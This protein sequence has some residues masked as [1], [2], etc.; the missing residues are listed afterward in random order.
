LSLSPKKLTREG[1]VPFS[2]EEKKKTKEIYD[3]MSSQALRVLAFA[4]CPLENY[5]KNDCKKESEK[6]LIWVGMM[7]MIDPP[8]ADVAKAIEECQQLGIKVIMITGD[9]E[10]TARAIA[11]KVN[12]LRSNSKFAIDNSDNFVI[13]GRY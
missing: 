9:Y 13:N 8:R 5:N 2:D 4:Y 10:V 12:L 11:Q 6:N 1:I 3:R 7:A